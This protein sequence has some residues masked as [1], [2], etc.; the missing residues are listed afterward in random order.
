MKKV[1][2]YFFVV[3]SLILL[4]CNKDQTIVN[5]SKNDTE[6]I[7]EKLQILIDKNHPDVVDIYVFNYQ[8]ND[9]I[10]EKSC[11][12]YKYKIE[13]PFFIIYDDYYYNLSYLVK[14]DFSGS[15]KLY[16]KY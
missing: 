7:A 4:N 6:I 8:K 14:F 9:W 12:G 10:N 15:L 16:F 5:P 11:Y 2:L 3:I 13:Y 1:K